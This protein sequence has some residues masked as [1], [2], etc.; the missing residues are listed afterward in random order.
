MHVESIYCSHEWW[1]LVFAGSVSLGR[2]L[3]NVSA[4]VS[5]TALRIERAVAKLIS[6]F[7]LSPLGIFACSVGTVGM[8]RVYCAGYVCVLESKPPI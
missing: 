1:I 6:G 7:L 3:Y 4:G 8:W 5:S 2:V